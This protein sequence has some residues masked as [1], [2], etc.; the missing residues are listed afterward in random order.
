MAYVKGLVSVVI[1]TYQ[2]SDLLTRAI[3]SVL[4]QSYEQIECIVVNDNVPNDKYSLALYDLLKQYS[5]DDRFK[6]IEQEKHEIA[7]LEKPRE[8]ILLFWM[9]MIGGNHRKSNVKSI[10]FKANPTH[11]VA[12]V[13]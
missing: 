12:L 11:V 4:N 10:L 5:V 2:R 13:L 1:P 9:M 8:N 7:G 3:D 6:F